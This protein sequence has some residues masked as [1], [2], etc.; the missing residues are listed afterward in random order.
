[1]V[2]AA[3]FWSWL[4][5]PIGLILSTPLTLCLVVAGRHIKAL[6]LLDILLGDAQALTMPQ[7]F[8]QR[9][10]SADSDEIIARARDF[11]KHNSF[12]AYCDIVVMPAL[13]LARLDVQ[14]GAIS[15]V[16]LQKI[17]DTMVAA[18][19]AIDGSGGRFTW[20]QRRVSVLDQ[21][22]TSTGR[23]LREQREQYTGRWQGPLA[24]PPASIMLCVGLGSI[25][26]DLATE[27][28]VR[29]L[30][31]QKLD[32]RHLSLDDLHMP[33][34]PEASPGSV[35]M[36]F[37]VSALPSEERKRADSV[38]EE[39]RRRYPGACLLTVFLPGMLL[40]PGSAVDHIRGADREAASFG[41]AVQICLDL[42]QERHK[43]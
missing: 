2:I 39:I 16:Q 19:A 24:V 13:Q 17:R 8:Y 12:A 21:S 38:A 23:V 25:A 5:G 36:V 22:I 20:R 4:W 33:P 15:D 10:L 31:D 34:P 27:L 1:V 3:I 11:L 18:I 6:S 43:T 35:S 32:A 28:L 41:E 42:L 26:D 7:R 37:V 29:I 40:Q 9:A 30:R 14:S